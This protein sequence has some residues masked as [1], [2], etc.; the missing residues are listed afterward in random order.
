MTNEEKNLSFYITDDED[1][2]VR[3]DHFKIENKRTH[4][5]IHIKN[6]DEDIRHLLSKGSN[7]FIS[8]GSFLIID[9]QIIEDCLN[10]ANVEYNNL[11]IMVSSESGIAMYRDNFYANLLYSWRKNERKYHWSSLKSDFKTR[12][13]ISSCGRLKRGTHFINE[14]IHIDLQDIETENEFYC[15]IGEVFLGYRGYMGT[16]MDAFDD[17]LI[18]IKN[19]SKVKIVIRNFNTFK[20]KFKDNKDMIDIFNERKLNY[21]ILN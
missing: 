12:R 19:A 3:F 6:I 9:F 8:D 4:Y 13:W 17:C 11:K 15:Y 21:T 7:Y 14:I 10:D 20:A 18:D 5:L 2:N 16:N 1:I